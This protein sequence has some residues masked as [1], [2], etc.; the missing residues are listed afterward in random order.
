MGVHMTEIIRTTAQVKENNKKLIKETLISLKQAT[1]IMVAKETGLSVATCNTLLNELARSEEIIEVKLEKKVSGAGR[2]SKTYRINEEFQL[3]SSLS[4]CEKQGKAF[5]SCSIFDFMGNIL[6]EKELTENNITYN[7]IQQLLQS[8]FAEYN[9]IKL[10]SIGIEATLDSEGAI[11]NSSFTALN[12]INLIQ[13]IEDDFGLPAMIDTRI[14][15]IT[16]GFY[17]EL[18]DSTLKNVIT[19]SFQGSKCTSAGIL[20]NGQLL[21]GKDNAA[22]DLTLLNTPTES[23]QR[24]IFHTTSKSTT[25]DIIA[26]IISTFIQILNPDVIMLTGSGINVS[27]IGTLSSA[28]THYVPEEHMPELTYVQ[29]PDDYY[30]IGL[31]ESTMQ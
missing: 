5:L 31:T 19:L 3:L 27:M 25:E 23:A 18:A 10:I 8:A 14:N 17:Q 9:S 28:C 15:L 6:F 30:R 13:N 20:I 12:G 4:I 11:Q 7:N 16:Y 29:D 21:H 1:K 2:P 22:C 24:G 26:R